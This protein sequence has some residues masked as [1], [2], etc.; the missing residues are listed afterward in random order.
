MTA[1]VLESAT[2]YVLSRQ[3]LEHLLEE[4]PTIM[5]E[6]MKWLQTEKFKASESFA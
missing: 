5:V 4:Q 1:K 2:L 3:S 6:Y